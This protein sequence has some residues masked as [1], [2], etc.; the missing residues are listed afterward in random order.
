MSRRLRGWFVMLLI[1]DPLARTVRVGVAVER[2]S[3]EMLGMVRPRWV[4]LAPGRR[5]PRGDA[6]RD[7][8]RRLNNTGRQLQSR[9]LIVSGQR[10]PW[11]QWAAYQDYLRGGTLAAPCCWRHWLHDWPQCERQCASNHCHGRAADVQARA[12]RRLGWESVGLWDDAR[13]QLRRHGLCLPVPGE[14]WHVE[15]GGTWRA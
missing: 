13:I 1:S 6:G 11:E 4:R 3:G 8:V 10:S 9:L 5:W 2:E 15:I 14:P 12:S 7:L